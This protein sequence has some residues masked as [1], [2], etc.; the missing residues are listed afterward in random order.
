MTFVT[1]FCSLHLARRRMPK[2]IPY[3][4]SLRVTRTG[5]GNLRFCHHYQCFSNIYLKIDDFVLSST[6]APARVVYNLQ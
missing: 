6:D 5:F 3:L 1:Y 4:V 2:L